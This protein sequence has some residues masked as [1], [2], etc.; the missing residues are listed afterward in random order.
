[1]SDQQGDWWDGKGEQPDD[2]ATP[3]SGIPE[4]AVGA[5]PDATVVVPA[6]QAP[7]VQA[8]P[9]QQA[10]PQQQAPP[11]QYGGAPPAPAQPYGDPAAQ[12]PQYGAPQQYAAPPQGYPP[13]GAAPQG[14]P[15]Q[16]AAPQ[17]G[18]APQQAPPAYGAPQF[19]APGSAPATKYRAKGGSITMIVGALLAILGTFLPW[20]SQ[21][22]F[23][24]NGYEQYPIGD[25]FDAVLWTNPG[26]WVAGTMALVVVMGVIVLAT[27]RS[28][29]TWLLSILAVGLAGLTTL[30][31]L[32][33][34]GSV[35]DQFNFDVAAGIGL[36]L[37]GA[38]ISGVGSLI[39]AF[40]KR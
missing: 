15:P 40:K 36:C 17:Y 6:R 30:A 31:A 9:P 5:D 25:S 38:V 16:G 35:V 34:V 33:A 21:G 28:I 18:G 8:P 14:F 2:S 37:L 29:A 27:G 12:P 22:S 20:V 13:Q 4:S 32:G 24:L 19:V 10:P 3:P 26:A 1:M 11:P 7:A 23:N 39:V